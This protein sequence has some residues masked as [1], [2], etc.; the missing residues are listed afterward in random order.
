MNKVNFLLI[1]LLI[2]V[3]LNAQAVGPKIAVNEKEYDFGTIVEGAIV[4]HEFFITNEGTENLVIIKV[5][6]S[7]G[8]TVAK[9]Q[10]DVLEPGESTVLKVTFNSAHKRGDR[11]NYVS[12]FTNDKTNKKFTIIT[13]AKV[14]GRD[15]Q[16]DEIKNA[17]I[18][19]LSKLYN[20]F[21]T[22][23]EGSVLELDV[24]VRNTGKSDLKIEK[25]HASCGC[26]AALMSEK[27]IKPG[28][29]GNLHIELDTS[30]MKGK[31]TRT[32]LIRS[33]DPVNPRLIITLFVNVE[34]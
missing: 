15:E 24:I 14:L 34:K 23:K 4:S 16:P 33:N 25:V 11:K 9:P 19:S 30:N 3:S 20:N 17:P 7:C 22:V 8:C 6:A 27:I 2:A 5:S 18:I 10:D 21:G 28:E 26:T 1:S 29:N 13:T 32:V 12:V 31:K